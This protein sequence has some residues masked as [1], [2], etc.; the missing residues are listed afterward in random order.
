MLVVVLITF[1]IRDEDRYI[2][3]GVNDEE[4]ESLLPQEAS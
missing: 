4:Q 3:L 2:P 1:L